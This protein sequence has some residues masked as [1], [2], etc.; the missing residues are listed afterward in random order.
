MNPV[1]Q[2]IEDAGPINIQALDLTDAQL[3]DFES[4]VCDN[5]GCWV[6]FD[7]IVP[8]EEEEKDAPAGAKKAPAKAP[9]K[10]KP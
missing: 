1:D 9:A 2:S 6:Y 10:G 3:R 7:K 8:A 5:K 4:S